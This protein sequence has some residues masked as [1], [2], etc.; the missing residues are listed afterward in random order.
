MGPADSRIA[1]A[2]PI[3]APRLVALRIVFPPPVF[4]GVPRL[5]DQ[6]SRPSNAVGPGIILPHVR[7]RS[8]RRIAA[9]VT[10]VFIRCP[11]R[12]G[13]PSSA[14]S[15]G[16]AKLL[17]FSLEHVVEAPLGKLDPGGE[18]EISGLLHVLDDAAQ[19]QGAPGPAD[20]VWMHRE[21]DV[22]RMLRAALR[23]EL[24]EI[25][26]PGL[27]PVIRI[28]VFAMA[29]AEQRA[30]PERL[31]R[32]LDQE[33]AVLLPQ[34]RQLLVKAVRV[35]HE[36]IVDQEL[37]GVGALGARAPAIA[38]PP[39][40]L[41]DHG[42]RLLHHLIFLIGRQTAGD[43]VIVAVAFDDMAVIEDSLHRL[44]EALRDRPAGQ[45]GRLD[46]LFLQNAQQPVDRMV[47]AVLTLAPHFVV[48][49]AVLIRLHVLAALEIEGQKNRGPLPARPADQMVVVVFL[50]HG[51]SLKWLERMLAPLPQAW[52][53]PRAG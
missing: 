10:A 44:R 2:I 46:V 48:Q 13:A 27:E 18:P 38:A 3:A 31:A 8:D 24:V 34:E 53:H 41:L 43:L 47:G 1:A 32:Q 14:L 23:I 30:I 25:G 12:D 9:P 11:A 36:A 5:I 52:R 49:N 7:K 29:V 19:R 35:E 40:A 6:V 4:G 39:R 33:L 45:E 17:A 42:D 15:G 21:R 16:C 51:V 37:N 28:A 26:L 50:Q 22:F 20:D